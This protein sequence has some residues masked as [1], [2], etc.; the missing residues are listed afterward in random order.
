M[1][2][3][4]LKCLKMTLQTILFNLR[5]YQTLL[6]E[7]IGKKK[8]V[9]YLEKRTATQGWLHNSIAEMFEA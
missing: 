5:L 9:L 6:D 4:L 2:R 3:V 8:D 1:P 7:N